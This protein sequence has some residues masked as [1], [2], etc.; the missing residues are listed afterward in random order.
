MNGDGGRQI[1]HHGRQKAEDEGSRGSK[2]LEGKA[3]GSVSVQ[4]WTRAQGRS[5]RRPQAGTLGGSVGC[6]QTGGEDY[7]RAVGG[8][9]W[10]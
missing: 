6:M 4:D 9:G 3:E 1:Q 5:Q 8:P 10:P 7:G 2:G